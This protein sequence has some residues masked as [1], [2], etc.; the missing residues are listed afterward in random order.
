MPKLKGQKLDAQSCNNRTRITL[1]I[2]SERANPQLEVQF[3]AN[4]L[5]TVPAS[6]LAGRGQHFVNLAKDIAKVSPI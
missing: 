2:P 4:G 3:W 1:A 6:P 5:S